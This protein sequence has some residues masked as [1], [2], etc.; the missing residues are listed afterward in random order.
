M[1]VANEIIS[2]I[3]NACYALDV[4]N[5]LLAN[6]STTQATASDIHQVLESLLAKLSNPLL[7][8]H[9][10]RFSD[11]KIPREILKNN[12]IVRN[13]VLQS[14]IE[15]LQQ[16]Q[17][18]PVLFP[19]LVELV[20]T[21]FEQYKWACNEWLLASPGITLEPRT[22]PHDL[23]PQY[24]L[25]FKSN[26]NVLPEDQVIF[27]HIISVNGRKR[28]QNM[29]FTVPSKHFEEDYYRKGLLL[30]QELC[31]SNLSCKGIYS[32]SWVFNPDNFAIASDHKPFAAFSFLNN[33]ALIR[34]RFDVTKFISQ[35]DF[36]EQ[37]DFALRNDRR[38]QLATKGEFH[39]KVFT[40][41]Y[42]RQEIEENVKNLHKYIS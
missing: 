30:A 33:D 31:S 26:F 22:I 28:L 25:W 41:F 10:L 13:Y 7:Q 5:N 39:I 34:H 15:F 19:Q 35:H 18:I 36:Q 4:K 9:S 3:E 37:Y 38:K 1:T 14:L 11:Y 20:F 32:Q 12:K 16:H 27:I 29:G 40:I 8:K 21:M 42:P 24:L 23:D 2:V 6:T 17:K